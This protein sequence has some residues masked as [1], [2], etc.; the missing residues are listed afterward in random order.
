[1]TETILEAYSKDEKFLAVAVRL[2]KEII[3]RDEEDAEKLAKGVQ[4]AIDRG[5]LSAT[6]TVEP[7]IQ[8]MSSGKSVDEVAGFII[9]RLGDAPLRGCLVVLHGLSGTGKSTTIASLRDKLPN[10]V[11]WSNGNVYRS[12]TLLAVTYME[13]NNCEF[14]DA[15]RPETLA[16]FCSMLELEQFNGKFDIKIQGLGLKYFVSDI[17]KT[18]LKDSK[19]AA[20]LPTVAA[21]TQVEVFNFILAAFTKMSAAGLNVLVEGR[22][23]TL[24]HVRTQHRFELVVAD[25]IIIGKRQAALQM[26]GRAW[27]SIG[28]STVATDGD[29]KIALDHALAHLNV[30]DS[31]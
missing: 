31:V 25:P 17:E 20:K 29:V 12:L 27:A 30:C 7:E 19:L 6:V 1:M 3:R 5:V 11:A 24:D 13:Q 8:V 22:K 21:V 2:Q 4:L 15:L 9:E 23:Q 14:E 28:K 18:I 26:G 16:T 10:A